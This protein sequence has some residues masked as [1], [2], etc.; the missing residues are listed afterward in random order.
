MSLGR[1]LATGFDFEIEAVSRGEEIK[2]ILEK[3]ILQLV[4]HENALEIEKEELKDQLRHEQAVIQNLNHEI[5]RQKQQLTDYQKQ[6][7]SKAYRWAVICRE[8]L[9]KL[10]YKNFIK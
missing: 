6:L 8:L 10:G 1:R 2:T 9:K 4:E 5:D 7:G 3:R